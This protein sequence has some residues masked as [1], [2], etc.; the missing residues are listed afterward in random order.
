M[1]IFAQS[2]DDYRV[3]IMYLYRIGAL[4]HLWLLNAVRVTSGKIEQTQCICAYPVTAMD[5][6]IVT[7]A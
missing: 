1:M 3:I 5:A 7:M 2:A 6:S 4:V